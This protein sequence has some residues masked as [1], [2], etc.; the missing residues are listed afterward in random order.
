MDT[1]DWSGMKDMLYVLESGVLVRSG[2]MEG[3]YVTLWSSVVCRYIGRIL[4]ELEV[5]WDTDRRRWH[6]DSGTQN[7]TCGLD[8]RHG[9]GGQGDLLPYNL[10]ENMGIL[11]TVLSGYGT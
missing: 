7:R 10:D 4:A 5:P 6:H 9:W 2:W 1:I 3:L 11:S 8:K